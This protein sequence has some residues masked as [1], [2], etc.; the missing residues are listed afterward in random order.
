MGVGA[1]VYVAKCGPGDTY[2]M[3]N[4]TKIVL[5]A[6]SGVYMLSVCLRTDFLNITMSQQSHQSEG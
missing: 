6:L 5:S 1:C 2:C 4:N 3:G